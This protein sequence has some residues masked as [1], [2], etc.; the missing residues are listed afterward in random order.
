MSDTITKQFNY[1]LQQR[2]R[3]K[4]PDLH[5]IITGILL[6]SDGIQYRVVY[7]CDGVRRGEWLYP[8]EIEP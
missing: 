2:V 4:A 3:I 1:E 8:M 7:W 5:G 6:D